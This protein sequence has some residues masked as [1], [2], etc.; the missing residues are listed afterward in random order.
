M[1]YYFKVWRDYNNY[2]PIDETEFEKAQW[3]FE[4]GGGAMFDLGSIGVV[5]DVTP[6]FN[7]E[8]GWYSDYKSTPDDNAD[9]DAIRPKYQKYIH[10]IKEKIQYLKSTN[11]TNLIGKNV[12]IPE[13]SAP[14]DNPLSGEIK[15]LSDK[16]KIN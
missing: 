9:I 1:K 2:V 14:K 15:S 5:K 6:D 4:K 11:Q 10:T 13:L 16:F 7:R 12:E 8:L 3:A